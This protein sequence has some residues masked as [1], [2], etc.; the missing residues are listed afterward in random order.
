[1]SV[2][3]SSYVYRIIIN[4]IKLGK[5]FFGRFEPVN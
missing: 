5:I 4:A 3:I 1:M 2:N